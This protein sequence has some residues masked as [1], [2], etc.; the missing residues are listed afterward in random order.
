[1]L[2]W[3]NDLKC[4]GRSRSKFSLVTLQFPQ[5]SIRMCHDT[6]VTHDDDDD[7]NNG[8]GDKDSN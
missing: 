1:M 5:D 8:D 3:S 4:T 6:T 2:W 7:D